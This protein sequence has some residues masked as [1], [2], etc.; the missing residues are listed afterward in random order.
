MYIGKRHSKGF[1]NLFIDSMVM[2]GFQD[3]EKRQNSLVCIAMDLAGGGCAIFLK[4]YI[5][6]QDFFYFMK[7]PK[8]YRSQNI[9]NNYEL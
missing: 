1:Q 3:R 9:L 5:Q 2:A 4:L 7:W 8:K 6:R